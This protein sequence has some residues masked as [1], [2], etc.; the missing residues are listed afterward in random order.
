VALVTVSDRVGRN[1]A[2]DKSQPALAEQVEAR[3]GQIVWRAVV[4]D[5]LDKIVAVLRD[6]ASKADIVL[7]TGGTG[8]SP[9][10]VTPEAMALAC[11]RLLPNLGEAFRNKTA[12]LTDKAWLSRACAGLIGG[13][14]VFAFPGS[15]RAVVEGMHAVGDLLAHALHTARGGAH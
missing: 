6:A 13:S 5:D 9:R 8:L 12:A 11:T 4:T 15:P 14:L 3:G 2:D 1:E 10:D 7:S